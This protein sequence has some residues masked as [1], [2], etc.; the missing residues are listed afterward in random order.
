MGH[1][2]VI[3]QF[4]SENGSLTNGFEELICKQLD[5]LPYWVCNYRVNLKK[6]KV[7]ILHFKMDI[8]LWT[9]LAP[10]AAINIL[11]KIA[12]LFS[13]PPNFC[14]IW[15]YDFLCSAAHLAL[16]TLKNRQ[17]PQ[18][19][20]QNLPIITITYLKMAAFGTR[21]VHSALQKNENCEG[22]VFSKNLSNHVCLFGEI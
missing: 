19:I 10:K 3:F 15:W 18:K 9:F 12:A 4:L 11:V 14:N 5:F 22:D 16:S 2:L 7:L 17:I 20:E 21:N 8:A 13:F 6:S 1:F